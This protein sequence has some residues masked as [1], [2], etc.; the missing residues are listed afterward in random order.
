[1]AQS[2]I[3]TNGLKYY[4]GGMQVKFKISGGKLYI[5][6]NRDGAWRTVFVSGQ[7]ANA[8]N[9]FRFYADTDT[10]K[11]QQLITGGTGW[12]GVENTDFVTTA[13]WHN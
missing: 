7:P 5:Q 11:I 9:N 12:T 10:L 13:S 6:S 8:N 1:M 2:K 4:N 3:I